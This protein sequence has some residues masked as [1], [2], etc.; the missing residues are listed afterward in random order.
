M[1]NQVSMDAALILGTYNGHNL[2]QVA[3]RLSVTVGL[4][5]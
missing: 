1:T 3:D 5:N 4:S 2:A